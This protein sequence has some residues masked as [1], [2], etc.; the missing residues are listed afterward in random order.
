MLRR[1]ALAAL[2]ALLVTGPRPALAQDQTFERSFSVSGDATLE[3]TSDAGDITVRA[4]SG[5]AIEVRGR[6][7]V[8]RGMNVPS[9]AA[10]LAKQ[11]AAAP[12]A[13]QEGSTVRLGRIADETTRKAVTISYDITVPAR[14]AVSARSGSGDVIVEGTQ[15]LVSARTGSGDISVRK[16]GGTADLTTGSGDITAAGVAGRAKLGTGSG[17]IEASGIGAGLAASTGS[18]DIL[19]SLS[20]KGDVETSTGSG[21]IELTGV[22]GAITA[23]TGSGDVSVNGTPAGDWKVSTASGSL[24]VRVPADSGF[25]LNARSSSGSLNIDVPL[26]GEARQERRRV[27]GT[28]RGGGPTLELSSASGS[29]SVR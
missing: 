14:T 17:D 22:I 8:R 1:T 16:L 13:T 25:T 3:V 2:V 12:P 5:A 24:A 26:S 10:D 4:G 21:D 11:V 18:G 6:V 15:L 20:G 27:Q 23:S 19:A 29:I 9:N 7:Q 28:V